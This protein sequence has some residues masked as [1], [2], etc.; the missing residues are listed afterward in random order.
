MSIPAGCFMS[1]H[2][3]GRKKCNLHFGGCD[4]D[5]EPDDVEDKPNFEYTAPVEV[6]SVLTAQ[7]YLDITETKPD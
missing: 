5:N 2:N 6:P 3:F 4:Q 7:Q 1:G